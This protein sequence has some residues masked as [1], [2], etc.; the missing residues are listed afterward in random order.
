AGR[1]V[2]VKG[3]PEI[4]LPRSDRW[5]GHGPLDASLLGQVERAIDRAASKGLRVLAVAERATRA[6]DIDDERI[7]RLELLGFVALADTVRETA[8]AAVDGLRRA[9][10]DVVMLTGDHPATAEAIATELG[11]HDHG[12]ARGTMTGPELDM[13]DDEALDER[14]EQVAVFARVSPSQKVRIV[15][16][17]RRRG[18]VVA[19]T[20]DGANDAPAI[21]LADVGIALGRHGTEAAREAA[22]LVVTDD[23]I[24]TIVDAIIEGRALWSSVRDA[25]SVLLG[26][27]LGEILFTLGTGLFGRAALNA[28][29]L[30]LVNLMTDLAPSLALALSP[31]RHTTPERLARE[32]PDASLGSALTR[33]VTVR[34]AAT[35]GAAGLAWYAARATGS[36]ARA[37]TVGLVA[38]VGAQLG[39]TAVA[40]HGSP[41]VLGASGVSMLALAGVVQTPGLSQ[42]FGS[43]PLGPAGWGIGLGAAGLGTLAAWLA[44]RMLPAPASS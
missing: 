2:A 34:A 41:L 19:V 16:S 4:V 40:G 42:V 36:A 7:E 44:P 17:F 30:L 13:L 33:D 5:R 6:E 35:A 3:A 22:D 23:R 14:I 8:R 43:R 27:N 39:Q 15:E 1:R 10:V 24:E 32:G 20:G 28:R 21:R 9:G 18:R 31:P 37:D 38:L 26:G 29:Q 11:L 25:I 12:H